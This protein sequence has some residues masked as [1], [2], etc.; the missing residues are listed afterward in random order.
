MACRRVGLL[1]VAVSWRGDACFQFFMF[2]GGLPAVLAL[3]SHLEICVVGSQGYVTL[4][5]TSQIIS[6]LYKAGV[7]G[8]LLR[9]VWIVSGTGRTFNSVALSNTRMFHF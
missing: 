2:R 8:N 4:L 9:G 3:A 5:K 1:N 7:L 6:Y